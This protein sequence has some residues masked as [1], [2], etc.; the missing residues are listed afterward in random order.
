MYEAGERALE[1]GVEALRPLFDSVPAPVRDVAIE[2][3]L[4]F[5]AASVA[6]TT[7]FLARGEQPM[8]SVRELESIDVPVMVL[9]GI[10]PQHPAEI[11]A[12]YAQHLRHPVVVEQTA[13]DMI[14]KMTRF[15]S[16][17]D[18]DPGR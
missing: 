7:R 17:L 3:M 4:G 15:C 13:P 8:G 10:D 6:A 2:M 12:L 14:E 1:Q 11:A 16:D 18:W 5:D 9:P